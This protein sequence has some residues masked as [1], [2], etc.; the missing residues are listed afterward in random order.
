MIDIKS[1][2][3]AFLA[4]KED[5]VKFQ[6]I[7]SQLG[8]PRSDRQ[9]LKSLLAEMV[10][11]GRV[12][13]SGPRY[14][15][16]QGKQM[17]KNIKRAKTKEG[18]TLVGRLSVTTRGR[19]F[20]EKS[21]GDWVIPDYGLKGAK[22]GDIVKVAKTGERRDR[23]P[24]G[25]V[26][27]IESY[28]ISKVLGVFEN[29]RARLVFLPF[30]DFPL[31]RKQ[32]DGFPARAE[33]GAVGRFDR[34]EDG[35]WSFAGFLGHMDDPEI[36]ETIVLMENDLELQFPEAVVA[37]AEAFAGD[38]PFE[39]GR[40]R[41]FTG[42]T[43]FTVDGETA[44][45]FDD[46]LHF[47]PLQDNRIEVGI[48]IADVSHFVAEG[49]A[50]DREALQ[51]GNSVY[52]PHKA[53]P[54]LPTILSNQW[55][56][57]KPDEL[58]YT[59]SLV[60]VMTADGEIQSSHFYKG[61]IRS[62]HRLTYDQVA[63]IGIERDPAARN[64]VGDLAGILDLGLSL[65]RQLQARREQAGGLRMDLAE[66]K[67]VLDD[68]QTLT[69]IEMHRQNDANRMIEAFM[70]LANECVARFMSER[71]IGIPYRIHE[72]PEVQRLEELGKFLKPFITELS[73]DWIASPAKS[74]NDILAQLGSSP[75]GQILQ[76]QVLKSLKLA[77]YNPI[78][79]GH[80]GL[81]STHYAHFTS[82]IRRY[83]DL[84]VHR[85]L[86]RWLE[87][88]KLGPE[89]FDDSDL[90]SWCSSISGRE[91]G[92]A[93]AERSYARLKILRRL[94]QDTGDTFEG[95]IEDVKPFGIFVRINQWQLSGLVRSESLDDDYYRFNPE[96]QGL[97]GKRTG[98]LLRVGD[99]VRAQISLVD[100]IGRKMDLE[101]VGHVSTGRGPN[102]RE[103]KPRKQGIKSRSRRG[104]KRK[105]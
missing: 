74:L 48:H 16:P 19:G 58:R 90:E 63:A 24:M 76:L 46:A 84:V 35:R 79:R 105:F 71:E 65:S 82:P 7:L 29:Q 85:R 45:D 62:R 26:V 13:R 80:F 40:R 72:Q 36:D 81:A 56:S 100:L 23:R 8:L 38:Y 47:K 1:D 64:Q 28:G 44:R 42:E 69:G 68:S 43:V 54:M 70:C 101:L 61:L 75:R 17:A 60:V 10:K 30:K 4:T 87:N 6:S 5:P 96:L 39:L 21:G 25:Q 53:I 11:E 20:V 98:K 78:N 102:R 67:L 57:L 15:L 103:R 31:D 51:R 97:A 77:E 86:S 91:R 94:K 93:S 27:N 83:A 9:Y 12:I 59:L 33:D 2:I 66:R 88:P 49:S 50:L 104:S 18:M 92:A 95:V 3:A 99:K 89:H 22:H 41:D 37:E 34:E 73:P 52:L 14:W 55:C 32:M